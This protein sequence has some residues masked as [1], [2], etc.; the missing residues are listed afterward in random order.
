M[1]NYDDEIND[2][3]DRV[4]ELEQ[5]GGGGTGSGITTFSSREE[6]EQAKASGL[7]KDGEIVGFPGVPTPPYEPTSAIERLI[8]KDA[9]IS[10]LSLNVEVEIKEGRA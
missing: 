7:V 10:P 5:G 8:G 6:Y 9:Q 4:E 2:L 1:A 3:L